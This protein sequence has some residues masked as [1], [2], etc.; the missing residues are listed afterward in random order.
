MTI[1]RVGSSNAVNSISSSVGPTNA[2]TFSSASSSASSSI[3][4]SNTLLTSSSD[5]GSKTLTTSSSTASSS[6]S[7]SYRRDAFNDVVNGSCSSS[8]V[9]RDSWIHKLGQIPH[10]CSWNTRALCDQAPMSAGGK[11]RQLR[12]LCEQAQIV[13]LQE[14]HHRDFPLESYFPKGFTVI[15]SPH[16]SPILQ[17]GVCVAFRNK[18][19]RDKGISFEVV[20]VLLGRVLVV[21]F[22]SENVR[23]LLVNVHLVSDRFHGVDAFEM[24]RMIKMSLG[25]MS[26][27]LQIFG[28]DFNF[29]IDQDLQI[30]MGGTFNWHHQRLYNVWKQNFPYLSGFAPVAPTRISGD[31]A[32]AVDHFFVSSPVEA[33]ASSSLTLDVDT[34][35]RQVSD[36]LPLHLKQRVHPPHI[37]RISSRWCRHPDWHTEA[38]MQ[39]L[40]VWEGM[41]SYE[42]KLS[43]IPKIMRRVSRNLDLIASKLP[44]HDRQLNLHYAL[45]LRL[46]WASGQ[47]ERLQSGLLRVPH[48][49][50]PNPESPEFEYAFLELI[51]NLRQEATDEHMA[52]FQECAHSCEETKRATRAKWISILAAWKNAQVPTPSLLLQSES[53]PTTDGCKIVAEVHKYWGTIFGTAAEIDESQWSVLDDCI[54]SFEWAHPPT[55]TVSD[56]ESFLKTKKRTAPGPDG[57][58]YAHLNASAD[59]IAK[60]LHS[61]WTDWTSNARVLE[62]HIHSD[63]VLLPKVL[64]KAALPHQIRPIALSNTIAKVMEMMLLQWMSPVIVPS[65][66][67]AQ[68]GFLRGRQ[69]LDNI[70]ELEARVFQLIHE[71]EHAGIFLLDIEKAFPSLSHGWMF[72]VLR[73]SGCPHWALTALEALYAHQTLV[74]THKGASSPLVRQLAGIRQGSSLSGLLFALAVN[75]FIVWYYRNARID[76]PLWAFADDLA[77]LIA[78]WLHSG[79]MEIL[80]HL[81]SLLSSCAGLRLNHSKVVAL[82]LHHASR[83]SLVEV[84]QDMGDGWDRVEVAMVARWLGWRVGAGMADEEFA[85]GCGKITNRLP[86]IQ[87]LHLGTP[88][89]LHVAKGLLVSMIVHVLRARKPLPVLE[90]CFGMLFRKLAPGPKDWLPSKWGWV[91][92]DIGFPGNFYDASRLGTQLHFQA[93]LTISSNPLQVWRGLR[94]HGS[95]ALQ[96]W[97]EHSSI[98]ALGSA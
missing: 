25:G 26:F 14:T 94:H 5:V 43:A 44:S 31:Q 36:H 24:M 82:P 12:R 72:Y 79:S 37:S 40:A 98:A 58:H 27:D 66:H 89:N 15:N 47:S 56:V 16:P 90:Q 1:R 96:N 50:L 20:D 62:A 34:S 69:I 95:P 45:R 91:L 74:F 67:W 4:S 30:S 75:P 42:Q 49:K 29:S 21:A 7:L 6:T 92:R 19:L 2:F 54:P 93:I 61:A 52:E 8:S 22:Q 87:R 48:W 97:Q 53:G 73:R 84:L 41:T 28:G 81:T 59:I 83:D 86:L 39:F 68:R 10:I 85:E 65:L 88:A 76:C 11:Q 80:T 71:C 77:V 51:A 55:Y 18:W 32:S 57:V 60:E 35:G 46:L 64:G 78:D 13:L 3:G 38:E 9:S 17:G 33:T 23:V 63:V 70:V